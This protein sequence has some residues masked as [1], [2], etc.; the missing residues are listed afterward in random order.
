LL[1]SSPSPKACLSTASSKPSLHNKPPNPGRLSLSLFSRLQRGF[2]PTRPPTDHRHLAAAENPIS[3]HSTSRS[4]L[5]HFS[6]VRVPVDARKSLVLV[7][8]VLPQSCSFL[9]LGCCTSISS[10]PSSADPS[11]RPPELGATSS[12]SKC[13]RPITAQ[14]ARNTERRR[15][16]LETQQRWRAKWC[17][18]N[19]WCSETVV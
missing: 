16:P 3:F 18:T 9:F 2:P 5:L 15:D 14:A 17:Y 7:V 19:W 13:P 11:S 1:H 10:S 4:H 6:P 12:P 8:I